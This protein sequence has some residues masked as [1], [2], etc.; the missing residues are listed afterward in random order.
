MG[1]G[2]GSSSQEQYTNP[3]NSWSNSEQGGST[4]SSGTQNPDT[5]WGG[6]APYLQSLYGQGQNLA[7]NF[8]GYEQAAQGIYDTAVGGYNQMMNPGVN[9]QL[10]AYQRQVGQNLSDNI[11]PQIQG[12][13]G[14]AGQ[15]GGSRQ[16][17]SEGLALARGNQQITDMAA[18]LYNADMNRMGQAMQ[19]APGLA[20]FGMGIPWYAM[21]QYAGLLGSPVTLGGGGQTSGGGSSFGTSSS[22]DIGGGGAGE[23]SSWNAKAALW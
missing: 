2:G 8:G 10:E 21:N 13:A 7:Q 11:L 20:Q 4:W 19:Q 16:G 23:G 18:N 22:R 15:M 1:A 12:S 17:V 14:M 3:N 9:P 5:V 6:Q